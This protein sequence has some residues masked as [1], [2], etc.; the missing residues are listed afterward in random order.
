[1]GIFK[2]EAKLEEKV[3]QTG[4]ERFQQAGIWTSRGNCDRVN[5]CTAR[6]K[7]RTLRR[8]QANV[9]A[10]DVVGSGGSIRHG[11]LCGSAG[12]KH[13]KGKV[14]GGVHYGRQVRDEREGENGRSL[15]EE[16]RGGRREAGAVRYDES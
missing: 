7:R 5:S 12:G 3:C 10:S 13:R 2:S 9:E 15:R 4:V 11:Q 16:V 6:N 8:I 14:V 1:M